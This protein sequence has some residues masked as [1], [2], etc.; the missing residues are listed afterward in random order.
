MRNAKVFVGSSHEALPVV[1]LVNAIIAGCGLTPLPWN[2]TNVFGPSDYILS[3][4][5][6]L[7]Q[8]IWG[9]VLLATPDDLSARGQDQPIR[10]AVPNVV[11]EYGYLTAR[12]TPQRVALCRFDGVTIPS[13][14]QGLTLIVVE[15]YVYTP[16]P[17]DQPP[18]KAPA[19]PDKAVTKLEAWLSGLGP[20]AANVPAAHLLH[21]YSGTWRIITEFRKWH[22]HVLEADEKVT[23]SG[24]MF[25][26][27]DADGKN[28]S[29]IM[30]GVT[31]VTLNHGE[32]R[33]RYR[34]ENDIEH[35]SVNET[36]VLKLDVRVVERSR[37]KREGTLP[38]H[39]AALDDRQLAG[40]GRFSVVLEPDLQKPGTLKGTH[41]YAPG[42]RDSYST[43]DEQ[44]S[45]TGPALR[46]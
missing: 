10:G 31:E 25:L 17:R 15:P 4:L 30:F 35:A 26:Q 3:A 32:Y 39:L 9:A 28:G 19:L 20:V 22:D 11:F 45:Y 43:A 13:D 33:A 12:L 6:R 8:E 38:P 24:T 40:G 7:S 18:I 29:G 37:M 14:L 27:L 44:Y 16:S 5:E 36:G 41:A 42:I 23:V 2:Q 46:R 1:D 34:F 21:G